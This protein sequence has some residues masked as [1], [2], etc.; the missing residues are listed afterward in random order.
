MKTHTYITQ[1][2]VRFKYDMMLVFEGSMPGNERVWSTFES[3]NALYAG[4]LAAVD[5]QASEQDLNMDGKMDIIDVKAVA[6]GLGDV[7]GVK[8]MMAFDYALGGRVDLALNGMAYASHVSPLA[9]SGLYV[10][11]YLKLEQRDAIQAGTT[12]LDY[13]RSVFPFAEHGEMAGDTREAASLRIPV[14]L[15]AYNFRNETTYLDAKTPVWESSRSEDF[16]FHARVR[17]PTSQPVMYRPSF[18]ELCKFAWVQILAV[19]V[20]FW[21]IFTKFEHLVFHH[22]IVQTRVV[23]DIQPKAHRF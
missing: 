13:N 17:V 6:K 19:Y 14:I 16:T 12:R 21:W 3:V 7:H 8:A 4:S 2:S 15:N 20:I 23:S 18:L 1:P 22:R 5:V 10:D 9:G 11:G